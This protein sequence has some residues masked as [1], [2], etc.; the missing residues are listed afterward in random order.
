MI[1]WDV[2]FS[3][4]LDSDR[5]ACKIRSILYGFVDRGSERRV[6]LRSITT[7]GAPILL[8]NLMI[9]AHPERIKN[10]SERSSQPLKWTNIIHASD[11]IAYPICSSFKSSAS[12]NLAAKDEFIKTDSSHLENILR[13]FLDSSMFK[14]LSGALE[15]TLEAALP[16]VPMFVGARDAHQSYFNCQRTTSLLVESLTDLEQL[17]DQCEPL[18]QVV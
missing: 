13:N 1:L 18:E 10:L 8:F 2:L 5:Q 17:S 9:E 14:A 12:W 6:H 15:D 4:K 11:I 3:E 7:I 16:L